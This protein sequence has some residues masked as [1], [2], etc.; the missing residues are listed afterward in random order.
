M[1]DT[2]VPK[3]YFSMEKPSESNIS[4]N[5]AEEDEVIYNPNYA[6]FPVPFNELTKPVRDLILEQRA[7]KP[8]PD[9]PE[10]MRVLVRTL[11]HLV[12]GASAEEKI[13]SMAIASPNT[14]GDT[15]SIP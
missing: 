12:P 3:E 8:R 11:T 14:S 5:A 1:M 4:D 13:R 15:S 10:P 9:R 6:R 2:N 7:I